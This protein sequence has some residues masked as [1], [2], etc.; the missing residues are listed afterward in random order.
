VFLGVFQEL[1]ALSSPALSDMA[2]PTALF[3][4][5]SV[6]REWEHSGNGP[7]FMLLVVNVLCGHLLVS[8]VQNV[9]H[10]VGVAHP[11]PLQSS[12]LQRCA[13]RDTMHFTKLS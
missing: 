1:E 2:K 3:C 13:N 8:G 4:A 6:D 12:V 11:L 7:V 5:H 10:E 9:K